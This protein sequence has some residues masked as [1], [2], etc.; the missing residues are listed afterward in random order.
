MRRFAVA[1]VFVFVVAV[2]VGLRPMAVQ[3]APP[4]VITDGDG[5]EISLEWEYN[6]ASLALPDSAEAKQA[7][8]ICAVLMADGWYL[9]GLEAI[10]E[11]ER[12]YRFERSPESWRIEYITI[13]QTVGEDGSVFSFWGSYLDLSDIE[14]IKA[15]CQGLAP[16][17]V[18]IM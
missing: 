11:N 14:L 8:L 4:P 1:V 2:L 17:Q 18:R 13:Y 16:I 15:Y 9:T 5:N 3:A 6:P 12:T 10:G 7:Q